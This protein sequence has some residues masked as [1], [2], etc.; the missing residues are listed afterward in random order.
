MLAHKRTQ[1]AAQ[2]TSIEVKSILP[3]LINSMGER[4][5]SADIQMN[6]LA[7]MDWHS[8]SDWI[9]QVVGLNMAQVDTWTQVVL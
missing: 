2:Y 9:W 7:R 8:G 3:G 5:A 6:V 4:R 1:R